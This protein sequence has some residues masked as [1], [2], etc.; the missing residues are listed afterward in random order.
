MIKQLLSHEKELDFNVEDTKECFA[1]IQMIFN[2]LSKMHKR[3]GRE[4]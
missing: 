1:K 4:L 3:I 2:K